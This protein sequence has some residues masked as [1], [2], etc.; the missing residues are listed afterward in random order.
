MRGAGDIVG[1]QA[2]EVIVAYT[3]ALQNGETNFAKAIRANH[4][5][6]E[7]RFAKAEAEV[8]I[9]AGI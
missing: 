5:D 8:A 4:S 6:L 2:E 1:F 7:R 3:K 9:P